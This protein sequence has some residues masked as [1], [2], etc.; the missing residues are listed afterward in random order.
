ME[1]T[2]KWKTGSMEKFKLSQNS[3]IFPYILFSLSSGGFHTSSILPIFSHL[4]GHLQ[5]RE[6]GRGT[7][8]EGDQDG[9]GAPLR[10]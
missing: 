7:F 3:L 10:K 8:K 5:G 1:E 4:L 6:Q 9:G 2:D